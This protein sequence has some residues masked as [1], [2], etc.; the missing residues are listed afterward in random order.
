M[1]CPICCCVSAPRQYLPLSSQVQRLPHAAP[2]LLQAFTHQRPDIHVLS[3]PQ[4]IPPGECLHQ[5]SLP[6]LSPREPHHCSAHLY[7]TN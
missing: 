6:P 5:T 7:P 4:G 3:L 1:V 2:Y